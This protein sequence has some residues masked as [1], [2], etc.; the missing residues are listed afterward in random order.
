MSTVGA[1][2]SEHPVT[3]SMEKNGKKK[4][5]AEQCNELWKVGRNKR[6]GKEEEELTDALFTM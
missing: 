5:D 6:M 1:H 3:S 2:Q 4:T